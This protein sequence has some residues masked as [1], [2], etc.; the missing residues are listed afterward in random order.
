[1]RLYYNALEER[2]SERKMKS[3]YLQELWIL[4]IVANYK[5]VL[6]YPARYMI[7][8]IRRIVEQ[9]KKDEIALSFTN[10][11]HF[12]EA[13]RFLCENYNVM[14]EREEGQV[15]DILISYLDITIK[16]CPAEEG[17]Q[18][19]VVIEATYF[20]L[21]FLLSECDNISKETIRKVQVEKYSGSCFEAHK[22]F[23]ISSICLNSVKNSFIEKL[24]V[25]IAEY[26]P[27]GS[28]WWLYSMISHCQ[29]KN[30]NGKKEVEDEIVSEMG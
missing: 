15:A 30:T 12:Y 25:K 11:Q 21:R 2:E 19:E 13:F 6:V 29:S 23:L 18:S 20:L 10:T 17:R 26:N 4:N 28:C 27:I 8:N 5:S 22:N 14:S 24:L 3:P 9:W 16:C 7:D 1:M